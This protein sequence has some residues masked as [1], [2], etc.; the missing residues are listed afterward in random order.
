MYETQASSS[1]TAT[2]V[3]IWDL[4]SNWGGTTNW[5][6]QPTKNQLWASA[7]TNAGGGASCPAGW[8]TFS[9]GGSG[10]NT[11]QG[12]VQGWVN[13]TLTNNGIEVVADNE[14][15]TASYK[16][17]DSVNATG[18]Y[19]YIAVTYNS[20]PATPS[21]RYPANGVDLNSMTPKLHAE[22]GDPDGGT[23]QVQFEIDNNTTG[24]NIVTGLG[25]ETSVGGRS[26]YTVPSGDLSDAT[27]YKWR[28]RG[29]DGTDYGSWSSYWIFTTDVT[30]PTT[31][32][33]SSSTD[34]SQTSWYTS[35]SFSVSFSSTDAGGSGIAGLA[36]T[37]RDVSTP[38]RSQD[39]GRA[40]PR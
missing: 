20:F 32:T 28:V 6:T 36:T 1:C 29:Y 15:S 17:W 4:S 18:N 5:N 2:Q 39:R 7:N 33:I 40:Y 10:S 38:W 9:G 24:T 25:S 11:F 3:D 31:P 8:T 14:T 26:I 35:Q 34:P 27:T 37:P 13:G 19:P 22:F 30:A 12:L 23:G 21:D 16:Q